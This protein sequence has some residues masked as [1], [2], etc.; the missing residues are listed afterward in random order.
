MGSAGEGDTEGAAWRLPSAMRTRWMWLQNSPET[1]LDAAHKLR[2]GRCRR[3][4]RTRWASTRAPA[5]GG[6]GGGG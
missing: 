2:A 5:V 6:A 1:V 4:E 3:L